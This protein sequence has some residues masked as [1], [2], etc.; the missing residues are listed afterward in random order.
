MMGFGYMSASRKLFIG[1][2]IL[3]AFVGVGVFGLLN[4]DHLS[5][6]PMPDCPY[7]QNS[8][9]LCENSLN[10][11]AGWQKFSSIILPLIF[12]LLILAGVFYSLG[13][14]LFDTVQN[15]YRR[16]DSDAKKYFYTGTILK[17]LSLFENSPSFARLRY[18]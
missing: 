2:L 3:T 13:Q 12:V 9:S 14:N 10:H 17:W 7:T 8:F 4:F 18:S 11:I 16:R 15:F 5:G 6:A 1:L